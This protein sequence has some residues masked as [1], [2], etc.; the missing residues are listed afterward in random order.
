VFWSGIIHGAC[1]INVFIFFYYE[2]DEIK[3]GPDDLAL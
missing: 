3:E 1:A 2:N